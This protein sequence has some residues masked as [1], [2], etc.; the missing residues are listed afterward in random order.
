MRFTNLKFAI[1]FLFAGVLGAIFMNFIFIDIK[2]S[3]ASGFSAQIYKNCNKTASIPEPYPF[4]GLL[5]FGMLGGG[6]LLKKRLIKKGDSLNDNTLLQ[7]HDSSLSNNQQS[8]QISFINAVDQ[9]EENR[10]HISPYEL[11]L[12]KPTE[13]G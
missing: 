10:C 2:P 13:I 6:Y 9:R 12:I 5:A 11:Q 7:T 3:L 8:Q 4:V 1:T